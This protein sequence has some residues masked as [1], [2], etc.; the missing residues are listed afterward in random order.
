[1]VT[2]SGTYSFALDVI[3]IIEEAYEQAGYDPKT[4]YDLQ[5]A[6]RSL[7]LL[8]QEWTNKGVNLWTVEAITT[9]LATDTAS[10]T[11]TARVLDVLD[12]VI[13]D[14]DGND[15]VLDRLTMRAYLELPDKDQ[16]G[17]PTHYTTFRERDALVIKVW[18][19]PEDGNSSLHYYAMRR[20]QDTGSYS[21]NPDI[22]S[23]FLPALIAGLAWKLAIKGSL[24]QDSNLA[25]VR[26]NKIGLLKADYMEAFTEAA[27]EDR[28]RA[29]LVIRYSR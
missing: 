29:S 7:D 14:S 23:R 8:L 21:N 4:G 16:S 13:R 27:E 18:P 10:Y 2:T 1:M 19:V 20:I 9:S 26:M 22:P 3:D 6:R 5:T 28:E 24:P 17:D 25:T 11:C 15:T 12:V